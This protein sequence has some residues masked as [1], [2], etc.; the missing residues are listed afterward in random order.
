M[1]K[2]IALSCLI[3]SATASGVGELHTFTLHDGTAFN[4]VVVSCDSREESVVLVKDDGSTVESGLSG[5]CAA[6]RTYLRQWELCDL[7]MAPTRF[8]VVPTYSVDRRWLGEGED[9][10]QADDPE[11]VAGVSEHRYYLTLYN[12]GGVAL[13][14]LTVDYQVCY[15]Q[16]CSATHAVS[17][18][19]QAPSPAE[20]EG[21]VAATHAI[22]GTLRVARLEAGGWKLYLTDPVSLADANGEFSSGVIRI[23]LGMETPD[24]RRLSRPIVLPR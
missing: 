17:L 13:E 20:E 6:D 5:F 24:G 3:A 10:P 18:S 22:A 2:L 8:V 1:K 9:G 14:N 21:Q 12:L 7:F 11:M 23:T 16:K 15:S 19:P 4:A